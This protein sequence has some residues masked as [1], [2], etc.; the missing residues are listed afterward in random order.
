VDFIQQQQKQ[1]ERE[2]VLRQACASIG[3]NL[4]NLGCFQGGYFSDYTRVVPQGTGSAWLDDLHHDSELG[5]D[6]SEEDLA[7]IS[8]ITIMRP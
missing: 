8:D 6:E 3:L 4:R 5:R 1:N 2:E 7:G